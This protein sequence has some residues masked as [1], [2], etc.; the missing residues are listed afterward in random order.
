M[1][2]AGFVIMALL[3][4]MSA[5]IHA[6]KACKCLYTQESKGAGAVQI[7]TCLLGYRERS[8]RIKRVTHVRHVMRNVG[9]R[10]L[11]LHFSDERYSFNPIVSIN[12]ARTGCGAFENYLGGILRPQP[13]DG[14]PPPPPWVPSQQQL[15]PG[16]QYIKQY[17]I[18]RSF[19]CAPSPGDSHFV[20]IKTDHEYVLAGEKYCA[21]G[22][23]GCRNPRAQPPPGA[24]D[25]PDV[26]LVVVDPDKPQCVVQ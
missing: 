3:A 4:A 23:A 16:A 24:A 10:A 9:E 25:F 8:T 13:T 17:P 22:T 26:R 18:T 1:R 21:P 11:T 20:H 12:G 19:E 6:A 15:A 2:T 14:G 5:P 7:E